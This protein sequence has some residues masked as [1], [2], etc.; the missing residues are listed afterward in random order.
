MT[1]DFLSDP[2]NSYELIPMVL[3]SQGVEDAIMKYNEMMLNR[4][5]VARSSSSSTTRWQRCAAAS[6]SRSIRLWNRWK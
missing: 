2:R 1:F 3:D 5:T 6:P 4:N